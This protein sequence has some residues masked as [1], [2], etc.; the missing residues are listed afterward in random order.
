MKKLVYLVISSLLLS[1]TS[2]GIEKN[3]TVLDPKN[4]VNV[5]LWH[6]YSSEN[7]IVFENLINNFNSTIG[8]EKGVIITPVAKSSIRELESEL[9]DASHGVVT[10]SEMPDMFTAYE[11]KLV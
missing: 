1:A 9:T 6:Y 5:T 11:D 7:K 4:P 2:C 10:A 8:I 3:K